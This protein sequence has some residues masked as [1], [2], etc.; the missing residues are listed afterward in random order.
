MRREL[1]GMGRAPEDQMGTGWSR[2]DLRQLDAS[3]LWDEKGDD[4][5]DQKR[6]RA[7][8]KSRVQAALLTDPSD[9]EWRERAHGSGAVV[10]QSHRT[11]ADAGRE[12][13]TADDS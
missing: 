7:D 1:R 11:C 10:G 8:I 6:S 2:A 12:E 9:G 13:L 4:C 3:R 5:C